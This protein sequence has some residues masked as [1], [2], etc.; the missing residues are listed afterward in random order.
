MNPL[1]SIFKKLFLLY[2]LLFKF[3]VTES[4]LDFMHNSR[5][6][7]SDSI[8]MN[9]SVTTPETTLYKFVPRN[10]EERCVS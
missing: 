8:R 2:S 7:F 6:V 9:Y 5:H 3:I 1:F 4:K 10:V